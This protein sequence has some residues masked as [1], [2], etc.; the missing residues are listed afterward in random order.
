MY[1]IDDEHLKRFVK[2][3]DMND[4]VGH[5]LKGMDAHYIVLSDESLKEAMDKYTE[6]LNKQIDDA[7]RLLK[8]ALNENKSNSK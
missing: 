7:D 6:W 2:C 5:S 3:G 8:E 1:K 4:K